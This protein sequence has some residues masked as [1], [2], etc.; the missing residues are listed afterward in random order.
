MEKIA[1]IMVFL[2]CFSAIGL[3]SSQTIDPSVNYEIDV[4]EISSSGNYSFTTGLANNYW[5]K[6]SVNSKSKIEVRASNTCSEFDEIRVLTKEKLNDDSGF[7]SIMIIGKEGGTGYRINVSGQITENTGITGEDDIYGSYADGAVGQGID[8]YDYTGNITSLF[9]E[10]EDQAISRIYE[11]GLN[12]TLERFDKCSVKRRF[13]KTTDQDIY[14][15][16][17]IRQK[18]TEFKFNVQKTLEN[19]Y[20]IDSCTTIDSPGDYNLTRDISSK[21]QLCLNINSS[22]VDLNCKNHEITTNS[23]K[24]IFP[25]GGVRISAEDNVNVRNCQV[26]GFGRGIVAFPPSSEILIRNNTVKDSIEG[27]VTEAAELNSGGSDVHNNIE[28]SESEIEGASLFGV[29]AQNFRNSEV[30]N[31]EIKNSGTG[32][33]VQM[34]SY[35]DSSYN[36]SL[37]PLIQGNLIRGSEES[38]LDVSQA[39]GSK[40]L[41]N[42]IVENNLGV[43]LGNSEDIQLFSNSISHNTNC[44]PIEDSANNTTRNR[45]ST[46][47][48]S[49]DMDFD[50]RGQYT[51]ENITLKHNSYTKRRRLVLETEESLVINGPTVNDWKL[52]AKYPFFNVLKN[53]A[54]GKATKK[55][56]RSGAR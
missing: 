45:T 25:G 22:D 1:I 44:L 49:T 38:G 50:D 18:N 15:D 20:K 35:G 17:V 27:I 2:L 6:I 29:L 46:D 23:E 10:Q 32:L 24:D 53:Q 26:S 47:C 37:S 55:G 8:V 14:L 4:P 56:R 21:N 42:E 40:I 13:E 3:A 7:N 11:N 5:S 48:R 28:I 41:D 33:L 36:T 19:P 30:K 52:A 16:Y 39:S 54:S 51:P 43:Q 9:L 34:N 12:I 31:N